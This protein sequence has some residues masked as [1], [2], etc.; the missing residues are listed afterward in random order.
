M[1]IL[2]QLNNNIDNLINILKINK[3]YIA[4]VVIPVF[5]RP[6]Y[7]KRCL[8]T[9]ENSNLNN[10]AIVLV[11]DNSLNETKDLV[12][13]FS[14]PN[15]VYKIFKPANKGMHDSFVKGFDY[16]INNYDTIK[17][18]ITLDSDTI[19]KPNWFQEMLHIYNKYSKEHD[20][21]VT[22]FNTVPSHKILKTNDDHYIKQSCG[23]VSMMFNKK[24]YNEFIKNSFL[25]TRNGWDWDVMKHC[26][27]KNIPIICTKPSVIQH[28]GARG[29]HSSSDGKYDIALDF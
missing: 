18:L 7:V 2:S 3:Q 21:I 12:Q 15:V 23:G 4:G 25:R 24:M 20:I 16:L 27:T 5:N 28:I 29:I 11:D 6:D 13:S 26:E 19:H 9:L 10:L 8:N 1:N 22:G 14:H 17:Y